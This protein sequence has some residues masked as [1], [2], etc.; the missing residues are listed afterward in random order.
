MAKTLLVQDVDN[1]LSK[2]A[3]PKLAEEWDK[4]GLQVGS[5]HD[6]V[7]GISVSLDVTE[8]VLWEAVEHD[9]NLLITHHPLFMRPIVCL[10]EANPPTQLARLATR[11][12]I[13]ILAFHTNLD[14]CREGL[15]DLLAKNLKLKGLKPL[16]PS[17]DPRLGNAGLGRIG[18]VQKIRLKEL[19]KTIGKKLSL[20]NLRYVG[21]LHH[22]IERIAVM[23][24]SGGGFFHEAKRAGAD[25]LVTGDVKYHHALDALAEGIALI[26]IGHYAGEIG[27]VSLIAKK[28]RPWAKKYSVKVFETLVSADPFQ[29]WSY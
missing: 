5:L 26:D 8:A 24:G 15:N 25:L 13:N 28:L 1:F 9:T 11:M 6:P 19:L 23:T 10:D 16:L 29:F 22:P 17:R 27:M 21:D 14:A 7:R 18:H 3:P 20:K 4:I 12:D 2:F